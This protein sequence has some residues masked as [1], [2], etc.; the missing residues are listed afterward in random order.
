MKKFLLALV[1]LVALSAA[2]E[3][4]YLDTI[5]ADPTHP[6]V[7]ASLLYTPKLEFDGGVSDVALV[8]HQADPHDSLWPQKWIE[9][10]VPALSWTLLE[11]GVGGNTQSAFGECGS[12]VDVAPTLLSPLTAQLRKAGGR[13]ALAADLIVSPDG[14]GLKI[15][16]SWKGNFVQGGGITRFDDLRFAPR[17]KLGYNYKFK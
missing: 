17:L 3:A 6:K 8:F 4:A 15:G 7:S 11:C 2:S 5:V 16:W 13:Y 12:S 10:G 1:A 14:N 9:S